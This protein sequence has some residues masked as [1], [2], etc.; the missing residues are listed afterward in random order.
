MRCLA[1]IGSGAFYA[2]VV[3][4]TG[5]AGSQIA[6]L[7]SPR[8][9]DS[10]QTKLP[11]PAL[12]N[13]FMRER[14][15]ATSRA[16]KQKSWISEDEKSEQPLLFA[17]DAE[18]NEIDIYSLPGMK[19]KGQLTG[20][21]I[22]YP[23]GLCSNAAGNVYVTEQGNMFSKSD[24]PEIDEYSRT[25][26]LLARIP[27]TYGF[28][29]GCAVDPTSGA[30]AVTDV[31]TA[32]ELAGN[33]LV[34]SGS[35]STPRVLINSTQYF[36]YF[37]GYGPH[38]SLWESGGDI[39]GDGMLSHCGA[40]TCTTINVSGGTLSYSDGIQ[41]DTARR[42]WVIFEECNSR[43]YGPTGACS[44][45]I[46]KKGKLGA[47][48]TYENYDGGGVCGFFQ[49][50]IAENG[51]YIVGSSFVYPDCATDDATNSF[52]RWTHRGGEPR[53]YAI[54]P[55]KNTQPSGVTISIK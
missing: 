44:V 3:F 45:P 33:V 46:S 34:F 54:S 6:T 18:L 37:V 43:N 4:T 10:F 48:T 28:P 41:W 16:H 22:D 51:K 53:S 31:V 49:G 50:P 20:A 47:V 2:V 5:C 40:S 26:S 55:N 23:Q 11:D 17:A 7:S 12:K 25:G 14:W 35:S 36:Y 19:L 38:S 8:A 32:G 15:G 29:M 24:S 27:D 42:T 21:N 52:Y 9:T 13:L 1:L 30:L 39:H